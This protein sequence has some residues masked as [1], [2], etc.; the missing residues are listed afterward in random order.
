MLH[1]FVAGQRVSDYGA[2]AW[3]RG[4]LDASDRRF[5][6]ARLA[7][8]TKR[9]DDAEAV[10][11]FCDSIWNTPSGTGG[12]IGFLTGPLVTPLRPWIK[13]RARLA[14]GIGGSND[15][16]HAATA[17]SNLGPIVAEQKRRMPAWGR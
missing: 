12:G 6:V 14:G 9:R 2:R 10:L 17:P 16:Q 1:H 4:E 8:I 7:I 15:C 11:E 5:S 3:S 13:H